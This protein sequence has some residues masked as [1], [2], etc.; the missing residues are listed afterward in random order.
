MK[1]IGVDIRTNKLP[2][3]N[4]I[5]QHEFCAHSSDDD[6]L[7]RYGNPVAIRSDDGTV[8]VCMAV[9]YYEQVTGDKVKIVDDKEK[10]STTYDYTIIAARNGVG[11][12]NQHTAASDIS[13]PPQ[14]V[15]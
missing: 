4:I 10:L 2:R 1:W 3:I 12:H 14:T 11:I 9:E 13:H 6:F 5:S 7:R 8:L 15:N